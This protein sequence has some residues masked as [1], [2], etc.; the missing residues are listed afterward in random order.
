MPITIAEPLQTLTYIATAQFTINI[1]VKAS[2]Q[3]SISTIFLKKNHYC[4]S[5]KFS[6]CDTSTSHLQKNNNYRKHFRLLN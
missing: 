1:S 5:T 2:L 3:S 6:S 4:R